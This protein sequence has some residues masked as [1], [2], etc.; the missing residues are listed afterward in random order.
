[1]ALLALLVPGHPLVRLALLVPVARLAPLVRLVP[2][3][4]LVRLS[5]ECRG[6]LLVIPRQRL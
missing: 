5:P 3:V 6:N 1:M 2:E 4:P